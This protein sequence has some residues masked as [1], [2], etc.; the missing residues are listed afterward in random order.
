MNGLP[1]ILSKRALDA[2]AIVS[3]DHFLECEMV[4]KAARMGLRICAMDVDFRTRGGGKSSIGLKDIW[5]Y[6]DHL[7]RVGFGAGDRWNVRSVPRWRS[8]PEWL[9]FPDGKPHLQDLRAAGAAREGI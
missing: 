3:D 5:D 4:M 9:Y 1:K 8:K 7:A 6:L 2:M